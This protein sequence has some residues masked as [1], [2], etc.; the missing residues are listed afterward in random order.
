MRVGEMSLIP[1]SDGEA[2]L[3]PAFWVGFDFDAHPGVLNPDG[4]LHLPLGCYLICHAGRT[5]L[6]DAGLGPIAVNWGRGGRLATELARAG[7]DRA[8]VDTV[9][10][11]HLH[12]DHAGGVVD[13]SWE[14]PLFPNATVRYGAGDWEQFVT[15]AQADDGTRRGMEVLAAAGRL[16]PMSGDMVAVAPG[17]TARHAPGHTPG[18]YILVL[19]SGPERA[20]LLGDA[21]ECPL[22]IEEPDFYALSDVDPALA[23][24]TRELWWRELE[25]DAALVGAAHFPGLKFGRVVTGARGRHW[26]AV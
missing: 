12:P 18:H 10:L 4:K 5:V 17:I 16:E 1:L 7:V 8:E 21:V 24:R 9:V 3:P 13:G 11:T 20:L 22:Q 19:S 25:G 6:L 2:V 14:E 26:V 23:Q 15:G